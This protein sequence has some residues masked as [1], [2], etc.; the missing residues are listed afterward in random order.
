MKERII[1]ITLE[2]IQDCKEKFSEEYIK[3]YKS[4]PKQIRQV[5]KEIEILERKKGRV[6]A[7][8]AKP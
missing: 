8:P 7:R 4:I 1:I 6:K 3:W 5:K 2:M